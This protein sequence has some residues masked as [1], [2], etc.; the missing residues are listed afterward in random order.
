[1]DISRPVAPDPYELLPELPSFTLTSD[2][3]AHEQ[4]LGDAHIPALGDTSPHLS[5]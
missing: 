1:M 3:V 2:D 5:W 4:A